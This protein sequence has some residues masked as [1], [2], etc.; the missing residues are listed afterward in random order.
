MLDSETYKTGKGKQTLRGPNKTQTTICYS[1]YHGLIV[2]VKRDKE[3]QMLTR[4]IIAQT[5]EKKLWQRVIDHFQRHYVYGDRV[6]RINNLF[7]CVK[8]D[9]QRNGGS[10]L[11][12]ELGKDPGRLSIGQL[13]ETGC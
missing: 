8:S 4:T 13:P 10:T 11:S 12:A 1:I 2:I 6:W 9:L 7:L 5:T 3:K